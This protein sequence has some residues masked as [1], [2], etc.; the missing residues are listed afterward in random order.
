MIYNSVRCDDFIVVLSIEHWNWCAPNSLPRNAPVWPLF[1]LLCQLI[2]TTFLH[3]IRRVDANFFNFT[4]C[5]ITNG[6]NIDEPLMGCIYNNRL[7]GS[8]IDGTAVCY[9][10]QLNCIVFYVI[11]TQLIAIFNYILALEKFWRLTCV[12]TIIINETFL[13]GKKAIHLITSWRKWTI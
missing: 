4:Q 9:F 10:S 1:D 3:T 2:V 8:P 7:F 12:L 13:W 11:Q 5:G 6:Q